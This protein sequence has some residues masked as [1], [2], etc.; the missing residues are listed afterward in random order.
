MMAQRDP[1]TSP[2]LVPFHLDEDISALHLHSAP[3]VPGGS[4][5]SNSHNHSNN[6]RT[7][8]EEALTCPPLV[9]GIAGGRCSGKSCM[10]SVVRERITNEPYMRDRRVLLLNQ[11]DFHRELNPHERELARAGKLNLDHPEAFDFELLDQVL[12]ALRAC[13]PTTTTTSTQRPSE[14]SSESPAATAA[15]ATPVVVEVTLPQWDPVEFVRRP[16]RTV[17][18]PP[19]VILLTGVLILYKRRVRQRLSLA[20]FVDI[21]SDTRLSR[22]VTALMEVENRPSG[23]SSS[24]SGPD[25]AV[26]APP[27]AAGD[28]GTN[29]GGRLSQMLNHYTHVSKPT[30][31]EFIWPTKRW[32]DIIVPRGRDNTVAINMILQTVTEMFKA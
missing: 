2:A 15:T 16:G 18:T 14:S 13:Y 17:T 10:A 24:S 8:A 25:D 3:V 32:A 19:D 4:S 12:T 26:E 31:E 21:D 11:D 20:L 30:F 5:S 7:E 28:G 23:V 9:V 6:S 27:A 22:Q 29:N 1:S